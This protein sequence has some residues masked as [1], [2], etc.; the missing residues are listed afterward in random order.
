M[1]KFIQKFV[2][3]H[4]GTYSI[5]LALCWT[6]VMALSLVASLSSL[7][8][9]ITTIAGNIAGAYIDKDVLYRNWNALHGGI[10]VPVNQGLAPNA[11][12]P[13]S[14]PDRDVVTPS[15]RHLTFVNPSYMMRQIYDL[16]R[17]EDGITAHITS[18]KP[19]NPKNA[20]SPWEAEGVR[21]FER[22]GIEARSVV[23]EE[24]TRYMRLMRPLVTEESCLACHAQ[25]GYKLG[26]IRGGISI[27]MPM[28]LL[29]AGLGKQ[30]KHLA[31]AHA[32]VWLLGLA[33]LFAGSLGLRRRTAE[34]DLALQEL[35]RANALL[36]S[37]ATTDPVTG[38]LNRRRFSEL[39][40]S[41]IQESK[42]YGLPLAVIFFDVDRFKSINDTY[43]HDAGDS[44]L[45]ELAV[46]VSGMIRK[47][48]ILARYG[49][50]EFV[51]VVHN[52]DGRT[53]R[54]LAEKIRSRVSRHSFLHVGQVTASFGVARLEPN[55]TAE[56]LV[57]R[58]D[59]AMY[60]AKHAG[61][62][63]V[64]TCCDCNSAAA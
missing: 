26:D 63:R 46:I 39:L 64:E 36:E 18:L 48:D 34:R 27:R 43:G 16:S 10:Y 6:A 9:E 19:L 12:Y 24:G 41:A 54:M 51:L 47:T 21:A 45:K 25:Q 31:L 59:H 55:D 32:A 53:A 49:G 57:K 2:P 28:G 50:E 14:M 60:S 3:H 7:R 33:G 11:F 20:P 40:E 58:A 61:R 17:K 38:L 35:R 62:N 37:Q 15:G 29:E 13:P 1:N 5:M 56:S 8:R 52:N 44:V 4:P 23:A 42:R 22:G 30:L